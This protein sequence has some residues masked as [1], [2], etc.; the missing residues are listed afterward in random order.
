MLVVSPMSF[1]RTLI[2]LLTIGVAFD[3]AL[4]VAAPWL[5]A[6]L[7]IAGVAAA[8]AAGWWLHT[9]SDRNARRTDGQRY[10]DRDG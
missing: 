1:G 5:L 7:T 4:Y 2:T 8:I 6:T 3:A 9:W 10:R